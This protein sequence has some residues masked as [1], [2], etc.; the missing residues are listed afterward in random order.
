MKTLIVIASL[1]FS[2]FSFAQEKSP[3]TDI[4]YDASPSVQVQVGGEMLYLLSI[5]GVKREEIM[6]KCQATYAAECSCMFAEKFVET[7]TGIGLP[8]TNDVATLRLYKMETHEVSFVD[9]AV[10]VENMDELKLNRE[11][12]NELCY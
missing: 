5:N 7:M 6:E 1:I 10:T 2:S 8:I 3:F 12:K 11:L 9:Q 4:S